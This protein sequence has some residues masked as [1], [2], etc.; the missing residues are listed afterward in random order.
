MKPCRKPGKII[1]TFRDV[2]RLQ[3]WLTWL[4]R[5][6]CKTVFHFKSQNSPTVC[7][8]FRIQISESNLG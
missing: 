3:F 7:N 8:R 6:F 2:P 4:L 1:H 5:I